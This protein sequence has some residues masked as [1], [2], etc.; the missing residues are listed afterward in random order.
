[1]SSRRKHS[2]S[3]YILVEAT[4]ALVILSIGA[5]AIH[6]SLRQAVI[7]RGQAEDYTHVRFLLGRV[8]AE[9]EKQ[10]LVEAG[11]E[12]GT[13]EAPFERFSWTSE[14]RRADLPYP[15]FVG[16]PVPSDPAFTYTDGLDY[17][18]HVKATVSWARAGSPF[19]ESLETLLRPEKLWQV[20]ERSS[21]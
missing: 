14:V 21:D 9:L 3:G 13:F 7:T 4:T 12:S 19:S 5:Y 2:R 15:T 17:L 11:T 1:M 10:P 6:A 20:E 16:G 18:V 8:L